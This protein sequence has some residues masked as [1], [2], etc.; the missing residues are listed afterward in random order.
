LCSHR[1]HQGFPKCFLRCFQIVPNSILF[2]IPYSLAVVQLP[3]I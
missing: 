1:V 2:F 3:R